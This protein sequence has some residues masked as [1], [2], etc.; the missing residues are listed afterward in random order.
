MPSITPAVAIAILN[1][2]VDGVDVGT[3]GAA[4]LVIYSGAVPASVNVALADN[5]ELIS[6]DLPNPCFGAAT[7]V[8]GQD[9]VEAIANAVANQPGLLTGVAT[10]ARIYNR[11]EAVLW[12]ASVGETGGPEEVLLSSTSVTVDVDTMVISMDARYPKGA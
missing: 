2:I 10:F 7:D 6:Y 3:A 12:Q 9:Y 8:G 4:R 5:D 1:T 11:D